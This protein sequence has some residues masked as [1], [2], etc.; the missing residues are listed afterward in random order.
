M[1]MRWCIWIAIFPF[2]G[3]GGGGGGGPSKTR[4]ELVDSRTCMECHEDHYREWSGS[5]H[6][7]ASDDPVF[8][9]MNA[10]GQRETD[11][12]LGDFCVQC[13]APMALREGATTD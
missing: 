10:R 1:T 12:E 3:C 9:A 2:V 13:H 8:L 7:Y 6:A 4:E 11:G 5:M